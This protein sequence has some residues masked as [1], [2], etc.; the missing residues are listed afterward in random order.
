[1]TMNTERTVFIQA[2]NKQMLGAH[3]AKYA[4]EKRSKPNDIPVVLLNVDDDPLFKSFVG[5]RYMRDGIEVTYDPK[6]LQ[7]FTLT[8]FLPPERMGYQGR[9]VVI[10]PDIFACTDIHELFNMDLEGKALA[11]C[12]AKQ[13]SFESSMMLLDCSKLT[14]WKVGDYLEKL[15]KKEIDYADIIRMRK[16]DPEI[17]KELPRIWNSIDVL[18]NETKM[19]HT[20]KRETQPW[21]TG[22]PIDF[23][24][25]MKPILG[26]IPREPFLVMTGKVSRTYQPHA[27]PNI[28]KFFFTLVRDAIKDGAITEA[29][30]KDE[31]AQGHVRK[32]AFEV[33][34]K[35]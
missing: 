31:I 9:A 3:I 34:A 10:D 7:S 22:L 26:F 15:R 20:S 17:V 4:I 23:E 28:E 5:T 16:I 2:N 27:D 24:R 30:V 11:A 29:M 32:D 33:I 6:D 12:K 19:L 21:R 35:L 13:G 25:N 1:M 8:R 18:T 14:D